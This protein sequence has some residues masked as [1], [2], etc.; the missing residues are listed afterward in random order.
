MP[1]VTS[2]PGN[3]TVQRCLVPA[4]RVRVGYGVGDERGGGGVVLE[5]VGLGAAGVAGFVGA[6]TGDRRVGYEYLGRSRDGRAYRRQF[7]DIAFMPGN[8]TVQRRSM[9]AVRVRVGDRVG[10]ERRGSFVEL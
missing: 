8:L 1:E 3:L 5:R 2:A 6:G 7:P 10:D 4:E 9:P